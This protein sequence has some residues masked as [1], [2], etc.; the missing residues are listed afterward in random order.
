LG[1][2]C[3][4]NIDPDLIFSALVSGRREGALFLEQR[5]HHVAHRGEQPSHHAHHVP[6]A[7][8][9]FQGALEP[10]EGNQ[11]RQCDQIGLIFAYWAVF[12]LA[13]FKKN[14]VSEVAQIFG[15]FFQGKSY[16]LILTEID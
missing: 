1:K 13:V 16:V 7:V 8:P 14:N 15:S 6:R 10:G 5:V 12:T 3:D 2:N 11:L 4:Y 9:H